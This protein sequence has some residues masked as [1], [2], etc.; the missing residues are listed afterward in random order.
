MLR[1]FKLVLIFSITFV[2]NISPALMLPVSVDDLSQNSEAIAVA[3]VV[4]VQSKYTQIDK[5]AW[6]VETTTKFLVQEVM[7]GNVEKEI[8][9][10]LPGG[11]V[12]EKG[13][14]VEHIPNFKKDEEYVLFL[15]KEG[16]DYF[17]LYAEA[18]VYR[19]KDEKVE[20]TAQSKANFLNQFLKGNSTPQTQSPSLPE[21]GAWGCSLNR[22]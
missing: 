3:S 10:T 9:M 2:S 17:P 4:D 18:G 12:G 20:K 14:W 16:P 13:M 21:K 11:K 8:S 6:K 7:K 19:I 1:F 15:K 5:V 22:N